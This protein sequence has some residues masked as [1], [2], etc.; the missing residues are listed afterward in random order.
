[1]RARRNGQPETFA[2]WHMASGEVWYHV[3]GCGPV[4]W[5][6]EHLTEHAR[7]VWETHRPTEPVI[8]LRLAWGVVPYVICPMQFCKLC[9]TPWLC[10]EA[11]WASWWLESLEPGWRDRVDPS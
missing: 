11:R 7:Y 5:S 9:C 4:N 2:A 10:R 6:M 1:V 3:P 8:R